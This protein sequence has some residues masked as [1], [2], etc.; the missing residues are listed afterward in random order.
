MGEFELIQRYFQPVAR[1]T[2]HPDVKLGIGDDCAIQRIPPGH[3]LV[4]SVDTLVEGVH[5]PSRYAPDRLARRALAV[6]ASDLAA[7]GAKPV[8]FTLAMTLPKADAHWLE[9]FSSELAQAGREFGLALAGGDTTR[10]PLTLTIQVHGTVP[11]GQ[12]LLRSGAQPGDLVVVS[13]TLGDAAAALDYL[14]TGAPSQY[15]QTLLDRY[16]RPQPRLALGQLLRNRASAAIDISDGLLADLGHLLQASGCGAVID[17]GRIPLSPALRDLAG[18]EA[19]GH[20]LRGGDDYEL[21]FT[22]PA[23]FRDALH[24]QSPI[25]LQVIGDVVAEPG[26]TLLNADKHATPGR[27]GYE[28]FGA[29]ND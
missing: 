5:F 29:D 22:L 23:R 24:R 11:E 13:G 26:L 2:A 15:Q 10:G 18:E 7:M 25:P 19:I 3:E 14:E 8:C 21:C 1:D 16:N 28:H 9:R 12:A 20:A 27:S 4:F 17:A 6:A